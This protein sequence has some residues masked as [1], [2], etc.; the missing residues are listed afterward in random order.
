VLVLAGAGLALV[1][2]S[3]AGPARPAVAPDTVTSIEDVARRIEACTPDCAGVVYLWSERMPLSLLGLDEIASAARSLGAGVT[4]VRTERLHDFASEAAGP[5]NPRAV[6]AEEL[7]GSGALAHAPAIVVHSGGRVLGPAILG[8]KRADAYE[9]LIRLRLASR[10][11]D[12]KRDAGWV[13]PPA[14]EAPVVLDGMRTDYEAVGRPGA[15]FRWVPG[16][17]ALAYESGHRV[18]LLDLTDGSSRLA[19]GE[20]DFVPTPDGRYFVTPAPNRGGLSFYEADAVFD[21]ARS[22]RAETVAP[23]YNDALMRDQYPSVGI[24]EQDGSHTVYRVLTS[25]FDAVVYRDYEVRLDPPGGASVRPLGEPVTPCQG[26]ALSIPIM[27][28][29]GLEVAARDEGTG[30][31]KIFRMESGQRCRSVVDLGYQTSKVA[32]HASGRLLA[33]AVPRTRTRNE[34]PGDPDE[35]I[36]LYDRD[37]RRLTRVQGSEVASPLAFP[38]FIGDDALVYLVPS[39]RRGESAVFRVVEGVR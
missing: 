5:G 32:W 38:D 24:L 39:R 22:G 37:E 19:P 21:A 11:I 14:P 30:T 18:Y 3:S 15:Y 27:S 7:V 20:I 23:F 9:A 13:R 34:R 6:I 16:R 36:F 8:Y 26:T 1:E 4:H 35:M 25:W 31:T 2:T 28:Q 17:D 29:D 33:F 12:G 10:P